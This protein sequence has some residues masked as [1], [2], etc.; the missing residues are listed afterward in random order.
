MSEHNEL[1][2]IGEKMA[3]EHLRKKGYNI[4]KQNYVFGKAEVDIV[5]EKNNQL[6]FV[7]VKTRQSSYLSDP[8]FMVPMK[9][10]KQVIKAADAYIKEFDLDM[11]SRFDIITIIVNNEY[12][13]VDHLEDAFYPTL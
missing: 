9:K 12:T 1:G 10:Q 7:E 11:E 13:K 5:A 3:A 6:V 4:L 8:E 2:K